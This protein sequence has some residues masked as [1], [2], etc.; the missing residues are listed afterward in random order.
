MSAPQLVD[1]EARRRIAEDLDTTFVVEAAAGTGKTQALVSRMVAIIA[2][3]KAELRTMVAVTFTDLAGGEMKLRLRGALE[4]AKQGASP[5]VLPRL[6]TALAQLEAAHI[7]T[8]HSFCGDL[9]RRYVVEAGVDPAFQIVPAAEAQALL[10]Q[11]FHVWLADVAGDPPPG[12]SRFLRRQS[13]S[14]KSSPAERLREVAERKIERRHFDAPWPTPEVDR[15]AG[16]LSMLDRL[17]ELAAWAPPQRPEDGAWLHRSLWIIAHALGPLAD[18]NSPERR[19]LDGVEARLAALARSKAWNWR[20]RRGEYAEG[21]TCDEVR[22]KRDAIRQELVALMADLDAS[23]AAQL[24]VELNALVS[25]YEQL[26]AQGGRLDFN[27]LLLGARNL[28]R[29]HPSVRA[30]LQQDVTHVLVDELQD[31]D[32]LQAE[33]LLL[34]TAE[35]P[36]ATRWQDTRPSPGR[37]FMVGDPKQS[38]YRFRRAD[39]QF[40][41]SMTEH[42]VSRGAERLHLTSSFRAPARLQSVINRAFQPL[43]DPARFPTQAAYVPLSP[44]RADEPSQPAVVVLPLRGS[45]DYHGRLQK[46][47]LGA[48]SPQVVAQFV[49]FL[50]HRSG[51][52]VTEGDARVPVQ[53]RHVCLLLRRFRSRGRDLT[54]PYRRALDDRDLPHLLVGGR[55][56]LQRE[57]ILALETV[58]RAI[59]WPQDTLHVYGALRGLFMGLGDDALLTFH[60]RQRHLHPLRSVD[61]SLLCELTTPVAEGIQLLGQ[62]HR[63][64]NRRPFAETIDQFLREV[65]AAAGLALGGGEQALAN[66]TR[67]SELAREVEAQGCGSFRAFIAHMQ[68]QREAVGAAEAEAL[69]Q[70]AEGVRLMTVHHAKGL[71]FPVVILC[72]P[73]APAEVTNLSHWVDSEGGLW[74]EPVQDLVPLPLRTNQAEVRRLDNEELVRLAYVA[75]TRARDLLV[76]LSVRDPAAPAE[77]DNWC[78]PLAPVLHAPLSERTPPRDILWWESDAPPVSP[79]GLRGM[80]LLAPGGEDPVDPE[81]WLR[82][83]TERLAQGTATSHRILRVSARTSA[84]LLPP[85]ARNIPVEVVEPVSPVPHAAGGRRFG[86]LVH[87][88]A[89]RAFAQR[90][91]AWTAAARTLRRRL[92]ATA[93]ELDA[94]TIIVSNMSSHPLWTRALAADRCYWEHPLSW[95]SPEGDRWEGAADLLFCEGDGW[96]VVEFKTDAQRHDQRRY[97][98]QLRMYA[99][100]LEQ[101]HHQPVHAILWWLA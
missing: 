9:L 55:A 21:L 99:F 59:E 22:D 64:R 39:L 88:L 56:L 87:A 80:E 54:E 74:C 2:S 20:G 43:M 92:G 69:E 46:K 50:L 70:G 73:E 16:L 42:L 14:G 18:P 25:A 91:E 41:R 81:P 23:L 17:G 52:T 15:A 58:L 76:T 10:S 1:A 40:Y 75:A 60:R 67:V 5:E 31:T 51:W 24:D 6:N 61:A 28:L 83:R 45:Y 68:Q 29:D 4:E 93:E 49:D 57:E 7:G 27:D 53:S 44:V 8:I 71:E 78:R 84:D 89:A 38:V 35:D 62:L 86:R 37:L 47:G 65:R 79:R 11:A 82:A 77:L 33:V 3:G 85:T 26:K 95:R 36:H 63:L 97:E 100:M 12:V 66:V 98:E 48:Q 13:V 90:G 94:A 30:A 19:D 32:P 96:V 34:L 101:V 72:D